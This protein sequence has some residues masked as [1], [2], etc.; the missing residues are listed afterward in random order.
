[1]N[2]NKKLSLPITEQ[3]T[4]IQFCRDDERLNVWTS[5]N[6]IITKLQKCVRAENSQWELKQIERDKDGKEYARIYLAPKNLLSFRTHKI[7]RDKKLAV[8]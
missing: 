5:D 6:T 2:L 8:K 4:V 7:K 1:M 3:E